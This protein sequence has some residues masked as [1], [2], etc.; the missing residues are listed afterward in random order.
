VFSTAYDVAVF[1][2]TFY[3]AIKPLLKPE[4]IAEM[5]NTQATYK[6]ISR[7]LGFVLW[8]DD[9]LLPNAKLSKF[10]FGHT[11]FTGTSLFIDPKRRLVVSCLTNRVYYGRDNLAQLSN[12]RVEIHRLIAESYPIQ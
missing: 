1:G 10:S 12:F 11:G 8:S 4:T 2:A 7:G 6:N 3:G 5:T 9:P